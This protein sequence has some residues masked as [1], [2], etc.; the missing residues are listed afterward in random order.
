MRCYEINRRLIG[1]YEWEGLISYSLQYN[2]A[3]ITECRKAIYM[4]GESQ[5]TTMQN[6]V[7]VRLIDLPCRRPQLIF[8]LGAHFCPAY[9]ASYFPT[10]ASPDAFA[11]FGTILLPS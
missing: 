3:M 9:C 1:D 4:D 5:I 10:A 6:E 8:C 11:S 7:G 2:D